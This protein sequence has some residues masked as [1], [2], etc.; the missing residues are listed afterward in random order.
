MF[1]RHLRLKPDLFRNSTLAVLSVLVTT[2]FLLL[3]GRRELGEAVIA[4]V[5]LV[6]IIWS[7]YRWGQGPGMSAA[8]AAGLCFDFLFIPPFYTF[9]IG[10]VEGWL[11]LAIFLAV[12]MILVGRFHA[13]LATAREA[14]FRYE[15]SASLSNMLT[16]EAV[17]SA[18]AHY[19]QQLFQASLVNVTYQPT[20]QSS[21]IVASAPKG[22]KGEGNPDRLLPILN[23]WGLVGEIQIWRGDY[24][25]LP[26][27][28]GV[29]L[30]DFAAQTARALERASLV[31]A[32]MSAPAGAKASI[33][34]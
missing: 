17:T 26:S 30:Q 27:E 7:G 31:E 19:V 1:G 10:S 2:A 28:D 18:V 4:L 15:L 13:S 25:E 23:A 5:Y 24:I 33:K 12:A 9:Y 20:K 8:L 6:P 11:V 16:G 32:K 29:L 34:K 14:T 21:R 22:G 3:V